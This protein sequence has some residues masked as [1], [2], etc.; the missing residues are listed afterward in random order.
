MLTR[1]IKNLFIA[2]EKTEYAAQRKTTEK[3]QK[4]KK[5]T[6]I[7]WKMEKI[8]PNLPMDLPGGRS[9]PQYEWVPVEKEVD[10]LYYEDVAKEVDASPNLVNRKYI[11]EMYHIGGS[12]QRSYN[13]WEYGN[14]QDGSV[15]KE[16]ILK[17]IRELKVEPDDTVMF[18]YSGHGAA[19]T[20]TY[21]LFYTITAADKQQ[22]FHLKKD[23]VLK[24]I[25]R[26]SPRLAVVVSD[27]CS[28][29]TGYKPAQ[30]EPN[31]PRRAEQDDVR[32]EKISAL[33][34]SLFFDASGVVDFT[35]AQDGLLGFTINARKQTIYLQDADGKLQEYPRAENG[36]ALTFALCDALAE[37]KHTSLKWNDFFRYVQR[38]TTEEVYACDDA[39][40][41][42]KSML[43]KELGG[44]YEKY[45]TDDG[46]NEI[47][48]TPKAYSL[49][50]RRRSADLGIKVECSGDGAKVIDVDSTELR[51]GL[52]KPAAIVLEKGDIISEMSIPQR[53]GRPQ[54][55]RIRS[56]KDYESALAEAETVI[57]LKVIDC[58]TGKEAY[59]PSAIL[60]PND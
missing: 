54:V 28:G 48:Q 47:G 9:I 36:S 17:V 32:S 2:D 49:G 42:A 50:N 15:S 51:S 59:F 1:T 37:Y 29:F 8:D 18:Y 12:I 30:P 56:Q 20:Q 27:C 33:C 57:D 16:N 53:F 11:G 46:V 10:V 44:K 7:E 31:L 43:R 21:E 35:G 60:L 19:D 38:K 45:A 55:F 4:W 25:L 26:H 34:R 6:R 5:E 24:E 23:D 13:G 58:R 14:I 22:K 40:I 3:V 41:G 52:K 39:R